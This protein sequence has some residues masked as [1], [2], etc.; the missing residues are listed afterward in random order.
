LHTL[1]PAL[2]EELDYQMLAESRELY[3]RFA[4][5]IWE[6]CVDDNNIRNPAKAVQALDVLCLLFEE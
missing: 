2:S 5:T 1:W 3:L 6:G 4:L